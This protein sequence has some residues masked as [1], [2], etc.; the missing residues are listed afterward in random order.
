MTLYQLL[1]TYPGVS[2]AELR[3]AFRTAARQWHPDANP[4]AGAA[5]RFREACDAWR[6]LRDPLRRAAYDATLDSWPAGRP[7]QAPANVVF[8]RRPTAGARALTI[9]RRWV[10]LERRPSRVR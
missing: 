9:L 7:R 8:V 5:A 10:G 6:L 3:H 4:S 2:T 1:G